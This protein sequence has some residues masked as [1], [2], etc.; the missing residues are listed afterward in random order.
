M[1][2]KNNKLSVYFMLLAWMVITAHQVI[3]HDHHSGNEIVGNEHGCPLA[4]GSSD[5]HKGLPL[6][7]H[8]FNDLSS[9]KIAKLVHTNCFQQDLFTAVRI[10]CAIEP[11]YK[12]GNYLVTSPG[13]PEFFHLSFFSLRAPP[14]FS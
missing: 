13:L 2:Q 12:T 14:F 8:A 7:C 9:E 10:T 1:V 5:H 3:P 11:G 6:H 4:G